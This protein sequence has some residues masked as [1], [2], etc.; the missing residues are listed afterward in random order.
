MFNEFFSA[1]FTFISFAILP[2]VVTKCFQA[3]KE[4]DGSC[5]KD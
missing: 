3:E 4:D 2:A 1:A 5:D